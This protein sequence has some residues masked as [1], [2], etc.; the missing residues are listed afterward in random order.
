MVW[1]IKIRNEFKK[2]SI[3]LDK[4]NQLKF[5]FVIVF[6]SSCSIKLKNILHLFVKVHFTKYEI[7]KSKIT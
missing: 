3:E 2:F 1:I 6:K 7:Y 5:L 4:F